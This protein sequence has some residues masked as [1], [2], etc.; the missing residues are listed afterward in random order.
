MKFSTL[1][2]FA[3]LS[4]LGLPAQ[5]NIDI[6]FDYQYDSGFFRDASRRALLDQ[7][8]AVYE[9]RLNDTL[10]AITSAGPNQ[11]DFAFLNPA[12]PVDALPEFIIGGSVSQNE[13][14][15]YVAG[16]HDL[17]SGISYIKSP[18]DRILGTA[19]LGTTF[20]VSGDASFQHNAL[21][22]GQ[23]GALGPAAGQT[24]WGYWGGS[25]SFDS[26]AD[27]YFDAEVRTMESFAGFDFYSAAL[28]E[29]GHVL[30]L[31]KSPSYFNQVSN[32]NFAGTAVLTLT[33]NPQPLNGS[34]LGHWQSGLTH[35]GRVSVMN[36]TLGEGQRLTVTELDFAALSD[37]GWQVSPVPEPAQWGLMFAGLGLV[38]WRVR[39]LHKYTS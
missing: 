16:S 34:D 28:H 38:A 32:G 17:N 25:I 20:F 8:A 14:R 27:W 31:G 39:G 10:S 30:G 4:T 22:R 2:A 11:A 29:I 15:I 12:T 6:V 1:T 36:P 37:T 33:G 19:S 24:D 35:A 26:L 5:A 9:A 3:A 7:A 21:S 18:D 13:I 23:T